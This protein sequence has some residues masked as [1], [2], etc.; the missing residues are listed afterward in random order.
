MNNT[1]SRNKVRQQRKKR[2]RAKVIGTAT[3]PRFSVFSSNNYMYAQ[4]IDDEKGRT[5]AAAKSEK[6][7]E[8]G[9]VVAEKAIKYGIKEAIFDRGFYKYHGRVKAVAEE[10]RKAGLKI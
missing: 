5:L 2:V 7:L 1:K 4:L 10:A 9:R 6:P 3:K 8:V